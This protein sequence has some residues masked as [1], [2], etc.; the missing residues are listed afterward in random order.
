MDS[1]KVSDDYIG[2]VGLGYVG[3]PVSLAFAESG[4]QVVGLDTDADKVAMLNAGK[5]YVTDVSDERIQSAFGRFHA[6]TDYERLCNCSAVIISVP[7]PLAKTGEPDISAVINAAHGLAPILRRDMLVVL[8]STTYPGTTEEVLKPILEESSGLEAGKDFSLAYSPERID[9][10]SKTHSVRDIPKIVGGLTP[11]CTERAARLYRRIV[12]EIVPVSSPL[13]A[14]TAKLLENTFRAVNIAMVNEFALLCRRMGISVWE[15]IDAASTK[16]FGFMRFEPGPGIGGHCIPI[17]P[18]YLA[19]KARQFNHEPRFIQVADAV[20]RRMPEV[21]VQIVADALNALDKPLRGSR[22]LVLG[23][24]YKPGVGD[25]RESPA[26]DVVEL[27]AE[28]GAVLEYHDPYVPAFSHNGRSWACV[29]LD[30]QRL[31]TA[32]CVLILTAHPQYDWQ[33]ITQH[34]RLVV[35]TRGVTRFL[36][37]SNVM[38]L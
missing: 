32:D 8:E 13:V 4:A 38:L 31:A 36:N 12:R 24:A 28:K 22:V 15:V 16:P 1:C 5:S 11:A 33:W 34:A 6:T 35:D 25:C 19:W 10:G 23:V 7:T 17:D 3:L 27:L 20:N 9:P 29:D 18:L 14:E 21:V 2:V 26:M 37:A 30:E